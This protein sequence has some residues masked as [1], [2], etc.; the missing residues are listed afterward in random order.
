MPLGAAAQRALFYGGLVFG[1]AGA[2]MYMTAMPGRSF[3]GPAPAPTPESSALE[4]ELRAHVTALA[5]GIGERSVGA[6][7]SL[8]RARDYLRAALAPLPG[9]PSTESLGAE[10][11]SAENV[12][13]EL[14]GASPS[15]V[16]V[17][18]H[19]DSAPGTPGANDNASG[20][21]AGLALARRLAGRRL[22]H[23]LRFVFFANEEPPYF[24]NPG[25]GS[26]AHARASAERKDVIAVML[27]LESLGFYSEVPG[28]QRYP[29][30]VSALYPDR[31]NFV[32]FVGN[33]SSRGLTRR[34]IGTFRRV[35]SVPSEGGALPAFIPGVGWSD[36]WSFWQLGYPA[37]MVTDTAV[38]RDPS[39]HQPND[40][41][42]HL[43]YVTFSRVLL[44]LEQVIAEL[45]EP[46]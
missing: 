41:P 32:A 39:Y 38:Y 29:G 31:G 11:S 28:S 4:Q 3:T 25:M 1:L 15:L 43:D 35:A 22:Q 17:G 45:A 16:V 21:A 24:Q 30:L 8:A 23:T 18:A 20:V 2:A 27:S 7:D 19:Y 34:A 46:I 13:L 44:G 5:T 10:G 12:I 42:E 40:R 36:H 6:G 9:G 37:L 33:L 14:P 26:L